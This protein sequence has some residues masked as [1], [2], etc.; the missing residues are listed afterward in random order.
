VDECLALSYLRAGNVIIAND[1]R[2]GAKP[3]TALCEMKRMR[4]G[5]DCCQPSRRRPGPDPGKRRTIPMEGLTPR[6]CRDR[7]PLGFHVVV[8]LGD[9]RV[10]GGASR[11]QLTWFDRS[12]KPLG[13]VE[14]AKAYLI[15]DPRSLRSVVS[16]PRKPGTSALRSNAT[17]CWRRLRFG[18]PVRLT[19]AN[20]GTR[21]VIRRPI[22]IRDPAPGCE[23]EAESSQT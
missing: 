21:P 16:Y 10:P 13:V 19:D 2:S 11:R 15:Q 18:R 8:A 9:A 6:R 1:M 12:G 5:Y 20:A 22:P 3:A 17:K 7:E 14:S 4:R 23:C